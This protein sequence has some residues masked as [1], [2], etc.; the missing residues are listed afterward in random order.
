MPA[1]RDSLA[2][3]ERQHEIRQLAKLLDALSVLDSVSY[4]V[5]GTEFPLI[6]GYRPT[7]YLIRFDHATKTVHVQPYTKPIT[8]TRSYDKAEA[9][10]NKTGKDTQ[11]VVLVEVDKIE[12]LKL[13]YPNYF[14]DVELF[15]TQLRLVTLGKSA[16]EYA[17]P[18][19]QPPPWRLPTEKIDP[20]WLRRNRFPK[21]GGFKKKA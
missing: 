19:K 2:K 12:N 13:A 10:D 17:V 7:H 16:V 11:N 4:G 15:K 6:P 14:G 8:A 5:R 9:P 18:S 1:P 21:P 3:T 20:S